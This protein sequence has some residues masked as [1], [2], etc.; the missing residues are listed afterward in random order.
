MFRR[1][2][3]SR[4]GP[5][6]ATDTLEIW[7][8]VSIIYFLAAAF[9][10]SLVLVR[11]RAPGTL[12]LSFASFGLSILII[13]LL[14]AV[15]VVSRSTMAQGERGLWRIVGS[16]LPI[17]LLLVI[18]YPL[19][20]I[21]LNAPFFLILLCA[22]LAPQVGLLLVS[23]TVWK[24]APA[25][26]MFLR[27][28]AAASFAPSVL[29]WF[30]IITAESTSQYEQVSWDISRIFGGSNAGFTMFEMVAPI[31]VIYLSVAILDAIAFFVA[32]RL[33]QVWTPPAHAA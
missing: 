2:P 33:Q 10:Y 9:L 3:S 30:L 17:I 27:L 23:R 25:G 24:D 4:T 15:Y 22:P 11:S 20:F 29:I 32:R 26:M 28:L 5:E 13:P 21:G 18:G 19:S 12:P 1:T 31:F 7:L 6:R 8:R 14:T 16:V